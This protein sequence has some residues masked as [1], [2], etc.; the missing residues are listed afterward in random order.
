MTEPELEKMMNEISSIIVRYG[1]KNM[2]W[3][4]TLDHSDLMRFVRGKTRLDVVLEEM[5]EEEMEA[6]L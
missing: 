5:D 2:G 1:Y 4:Q 6:I 3:Q